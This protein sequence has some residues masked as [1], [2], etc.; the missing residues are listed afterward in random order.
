M[1]TPT[2]SRPR[3]GRMIGGVCAAIAR[4]FGWNPTLV[5]VVTVASILIPGPQVLAYIIG[6]IAIPNE[7]QAA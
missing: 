2:L 3:Q 1:S 7:R 5:R 6:W 4:R